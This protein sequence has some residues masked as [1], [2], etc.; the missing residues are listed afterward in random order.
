MSNTQGQNTEGRRRLAR[1]LKIGLAIVIPLGA[2]ALAFKPA[3]R[4]FREH[5][6]TQ[7]I[8][9]A[10][11]AMRIEDWQLAREKSRAALMMK[12]GDYHAFTIQAHALAK[13]E[14]PAAFMAAVSLIRHPE[15]TREDRIDSLE[16][17]ANQGP[18]ALALG[19]YA[20]LDKDNDPKLQD[21]ELNAA[22]SPLLLTMGKQGIAS[23]RQ[24]VMDRMPETPSPRVRLAFIRA[25]SLDPRP[26]DVL[27]ARKHFAALI[28]DGAPEALAALE[29]LGNTPGGLAPGEPLPNLPAWVSR[30]TGAKVIHHLLA[31]HP[32]IAENPAG[33]EAVFAS[34]IDRFAPLDPAAT[35]NWLSLH[36]RPEDA[37]KI[38]EEPAKERSDA[39]VARIRALLRLKRNEE[40]DEALKN[41]P[42]T[43]D[44]VEVRI[45]RAILAGNRG[46]K[47]TASKEWTEALNQASYDNRRN[48]FI[49]IAR[50]AELYGE[51]AAAADAW[52]G[53]VRLGFGKIPL[54]VTL[55]GP[56]VYLYNEG[57]ADDILSISQ[58]MLLFE[59][60]NPDLLN[61]VSYLG[62]L[63]GTTKPTEAIERIEKIVA[64]N[65][66]KLE[67]NSTLALAYI[68]NGDPKNAQ[69][70]LFAQ[71]AS[72]KISATT[73][74]LLKAA[75]LKMTNEPDQ[76]KQIYD[77]VDRSKL[78]PVE[79]AL[80]DRLILDKKA[81]ENTADVSLEQRMV[82][83]STIGSDEAP[84]W[85][86]GLERAEQKR[87]SAGGSEE[88][89]PEL[90]VPGIED[91][92]QPFDNKKNPN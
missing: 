54:Y 46:D 39:Y 6:V 50:T 35:A 76:A 34:A 73:Q 37:L 44:M 40:L 78:M 17:L 22:I 53:A 82:N 59:P 74:A 62:L 36:N 14:D 48:R 87:N 47:A 15:S 28:E 20:Y 16:V 65:P 72:E 12:R 58:S 60:S 21:V 57:R 8:E 67:L 4:A 92:T 81:E 11:E 83:K 26:E 66:G 42:A 49:P 2:L 29:L 32:Q 61:N 43:A 1:R 77:G 71:G 3:Y 56:M 63:L 23:V 41:P 33:Q 86:K 25:V 64:E 10:E 55:G 89:Y 52:I 45:V 68:L 90:R 30:Q 84:A 85:K 38:L 19:A 80:Y 69:E 75:I 5:R 91:P 9:I 79:Q 88:N 24:G 31:L 51:K 7:L 27:I 13:S 18:A 70:R